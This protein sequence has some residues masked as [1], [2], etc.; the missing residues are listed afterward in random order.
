[1]DTSLRKPEQ[2]NKTNKQ[3]KRID[4]DEKSPRTA[5]VRVT[6]TG[7][8]L[9]QHT[10][11]ICGGARQGRGRMAHCFSVLPQQIA[12]PSLQGRAALLRPHI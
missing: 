12:L 1:M 4:P 8:A 7:N 10:I 9:L 6:I 2:K 5:A 3:Y 11:R